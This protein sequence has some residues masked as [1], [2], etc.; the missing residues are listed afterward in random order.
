MEEGIFYKK[1]SKSDFCGV[2]ILP[3]GKDI[4]RI[5]IAKINYHESLSVGGRKEQ[6]MWTATFAKNPYTDKDM[7]LN[8]TNKKRIAKMFWNEKV[9]DGSICAGRI[10]LLRNIP[11]R[12]TMEECRDVQDGGETFGLRI[13]KIPASALPKLP[14]EKVESCKKWLGEGHTIEELKTLYTVSDEQIKLLSDGKK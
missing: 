4:M 14:D 9:E 11:V 13:S 6:G 12:L 10:N 7:L 3:E 5:V 1:G 2:E 8:A